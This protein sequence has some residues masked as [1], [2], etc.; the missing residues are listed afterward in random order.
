MSDD[1]EFPAKFV[2]GVVAH[3]NQ[4][5]AAEMLA[6][7]HGIAGQAW[8]TEATLQHADKNGLDLALR[9]G[10]RVE[11]VRVPFAAPLVKTTQFRVAVIVLIQQA[12]KR[13]GQETPE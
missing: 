10:E 1:A 11:I 2:A 8:A 3:I 6:V 9:V 4:D 13:L 5:H 12:H 7:A